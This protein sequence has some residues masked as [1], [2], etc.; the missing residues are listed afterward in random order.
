MCQS[1]SEINRKI[2]EI[3][4]EDGY[5]GDRYRIGF[6]DSSIFDEDKLM[7]DFPGLYEPVTLPPL[8]VSGVNFTSSPKPGAK[9]CINVDWFQVTT[10]GIFLKFDKYAEPE[11][12]IFFD[13]GEIALER[14]QDRFGGTKHFKHVYKVFLHGEHFGEFVCTPRN[15]NILDKHLCQFKIENHHL[16][17]RGWV[18]RVNYL[19][20]S[21]G[22]VVNNVTRLDIALDGGGF[23]DI[24]EDYEKGFYD[25]LGK[26]S[27]VTYR[28][29]NRR[30]TGF[31]V[32]RK[33]SSKRITCYNRTQKIRTDNKVYIKA[34]WKRNN[35][36]VSQDVERLELKLKAKAVKD[37]KDF[38]MNRLE[39][40]AYLA[41]IMKAQMS[42]F[43]EF[44]ERSTDSNVSRRERISAVDWDELTSERI[45]KVGEVRPPNVL[46]SL[47]RRISF[48][49]LEYYAKQETLAADL[50]DQVESKNYELARSYGIEDWF[51]GKLRY[52]ERQK[53]VHSLIIQERQKAKTFR[54]QLANW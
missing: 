32:G 51:I 50:F 1:Y 53:E 31:D 27:I 17:S 29:G 10:R 35:L 38:D 45:E 34:Y 6:I 28:T 42:N 52:W 54:S 22:V 20:Q 8:G 14:D 47:K 41:G 30:L 25:K 33:S 16:Y 43:Y 5:T 46:W 3:L 9:Y 7:E 48:D 4:E 12:V 26:A 21:L 2:N 37:I 15:P 11:P 44:V 39:D 19:F 18:E 24:H 36:D 40:C 13:K 23:F 49:M